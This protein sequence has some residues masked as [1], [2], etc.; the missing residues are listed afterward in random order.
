MGNPPQNLTHNSQ[1]HFFL[2]LYVPARFVVLCTHTFVVPCRLLTCFLIL[3]TH[4][5]QVLCT[6]CFLVPSPHCL[7]VLCTHCFLVPS[8]RC[9][10]VLCTRCFLVPSILTVSWSSVLAAFWSPV[11][12]ACIT[13]ASSVD[14]IRQKQQKIGMIVI[15][16]VPA[17]VSAYKSHTLLLRVIGLI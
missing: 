2:W 7:L 14:S 11:L 15:R 4:C 1:P 8:T 5:T 13:E 12:T 16:G 3:C 9:L 10:L 6:H 17:D